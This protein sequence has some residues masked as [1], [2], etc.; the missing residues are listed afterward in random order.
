MAG[1]DLEAQGKHFETFVKKKAR[2]FEEVA[3]E[4]T[5]SCVDSRSGADGASPGYTAARQVRQ[6]RDDA[7]YQNPQLARRF[8]CE[9]IRSRKKA[10]GH[11]CVCDRNYVQFFRSR[12]PSS[13]TTS[14]GTKRSITKTIVGSWHYY[15]F[16]RVLQT[17]VLRT[18]VCAPREELIDCPSECCTVV[19]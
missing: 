7:A 11:E 4:S 5:L 18:S 6:L 13:A 17:C 8:K 15:K 2:W 9:N 1:R 19:V 10:G 12:R 3:K 16:M 14:T